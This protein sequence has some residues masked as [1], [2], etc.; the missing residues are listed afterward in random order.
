MILDVNPVC[1]YYFCQLSGQLSCMSLVLVVGISKGF[2]FAKIS[3]DHVQACTSLL[4]C[5]SNAILIIGNSSPM[6]LFSVVCNGLQILVASMSGSHVMA[7]LASPKEFGTFPFLSVFLA[8]CEAC[9][10]WLFVK[11]SVGFLSEAIWF[12]VMEGLIFDSISL[13]I[14]ILS[15]FLFLLFRLGRMS[16]SRNLSIFSPCSIL[17]LW[18]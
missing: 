4:N 12:F 7:V 3:W 1:W 18:H 13:L 5:Y 2:L 11:C 15:K 10:F 8:E 6:S 16:V 17:L 9:W 14:I